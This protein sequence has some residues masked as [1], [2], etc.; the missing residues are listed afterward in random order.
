MEMSEA[1]PLMSALAHPTRYRCFEEL[2]KKGRASAGELGEA[3][4]IPPSLL[5]S[6][7]SILSAAGLVSSARSGRSVIYVPMKPRLLGLVGH[8]VEMASEDPDA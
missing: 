7:L 4:D 3:L 6:H 8:L 1:L 2:L 5:S